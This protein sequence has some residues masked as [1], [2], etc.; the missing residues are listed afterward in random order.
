MT[1]FFSTLF[2]PRAQPTESEHAPHPRPAQEKFCDTAKLPF[3]RMARRLDAPVGDPHDHLHDPVRDTM[4]EACR[5]CGNKEGC[6][7]WLAQKHPPG[8]PV[9]C[10]NAPDLIDRATKRK[11]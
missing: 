3:W 10:S 8:F 1:K 6:K 7:A 9:F 4:V 2:P 11:A 5:R